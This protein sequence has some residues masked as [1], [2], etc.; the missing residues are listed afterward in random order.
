MLVIT[1]F[2]GF[3]IG[4]NIPIDTTICLEFIPQNRRF[5]LAI[6]SVFQPLGVVVTSGLSYAFIPQFSCGKDAAGTDL[7]S[8][9][10]VAAGVAC[11][12]KASNMGWRYNLLCLGGICLAIFF[13]RFVVFNFQESP[14]FLLYRGQDEKAV[15]VLQ[16]IAKFNK[17]ECSVTLEMFE[18]LTDENDSTAS[19]DTNTPMLG[20]GV[21]QLKATWQEKVKLEFQRYKILFSSFT[22][23]RLTILVWITYVFDY[24]A[25]SIA[26]KI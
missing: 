18:A 24:W 12:T 8:C 21:K 26:G 2:V 22:M 6:L 11:C 14:K 17:R 10:N 20:A 19:R 3:G 23:A 25:F 15:K 13:L 5:L 1:A 7:P 9:H 4:G 16:H